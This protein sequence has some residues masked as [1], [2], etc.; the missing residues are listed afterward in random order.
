MTVFSTQEIDI[1]SDPITL[2]IKNRVIEKAVS[3]M[4]DVEKW[5]M[6]LFEGVN[7][8]SEINLDNGKISKGEQYKFLPYVLLD[9]PAHY[10][11]NNVFAIRTMF[12]W[13]NFI[14]I[15]IHLKGIY[16]ARYGKQIL[17]IFKNNT[18]IYFCVHH[19]EWEYDYS[20]R[21]YKLLPPLK[22]EEI[23]LQFVDHGFVKFSTKLPIDKIHQTKEMTDAFLKPILEI[24]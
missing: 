11:K 6:P 15:S 24:L 4:G 1:A 10:T 23:N 2:L 17:E 3:L 16:L 5:I 22:E 8:P 14:S 20:E 18:S 13:G 9:Y 21:N 12:Y 19:S 7:L